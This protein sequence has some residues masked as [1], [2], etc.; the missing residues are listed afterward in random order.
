MAVLCGSVH[1]RLKLSCVVGSGDRGRVSVALAPRELMVPRWTCG[2][3]Q[4]CHAV[5]AL[6][7][8]GAAKGGVIWR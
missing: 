6:Q 3:W 1:V 5:T 8:C 2:V 4:E 7:S